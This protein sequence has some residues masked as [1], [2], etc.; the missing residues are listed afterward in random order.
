MLFL[1]WRSNGRRATGNN[2]AGDTP[3]T[4]TKKGGERARRHRVPKDKRQ[5]ACGKKRSG[6]YTTAAK[7]V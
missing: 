4:A 5:M 6:E 3:K 2:P 1:V 7:V